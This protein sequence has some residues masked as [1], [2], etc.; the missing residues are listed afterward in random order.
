MCPK[1]GT[2]RHFK[3]FQLWKEDKITLT[4]ETILQKHLEEKIEGLLIAKITKRASLSRVKLSKPT[5][6]ANRVRSKQIKPHKLH[7]EEHPRKTALG[8]K[9]K[10]AKIVIFGKTQSM[11]SYHKQIQATFY[12]NMSCKCKS[13][14]Q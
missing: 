6:T 7:Q 5:R 1:V 2:T 3:A 12:S 8:R 4:S 10:T 13:I 11:S 14:R 9:R